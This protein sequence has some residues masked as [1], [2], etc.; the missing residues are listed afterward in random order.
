MYCKDI[1]FD[2]AKMEGKDKLY[3]GQ[4]LRAEIGEHSPFWRAFY[5][6]QAKQAE[7]EETIPK[8]PQPF[9]FIATSLLTAPASKRQLWRSS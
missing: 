1:L 6:T 4:W 8:T 2:E 9:D 7:V 5:E 3:Y